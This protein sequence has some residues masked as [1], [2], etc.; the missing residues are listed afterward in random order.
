[1]TGAR[2]AATASASEETSSAVESA[3]AARPAVAMF[4]TGRTAALASSSSASP[5]R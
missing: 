4:A 2:I 3:G 1:M 5:V